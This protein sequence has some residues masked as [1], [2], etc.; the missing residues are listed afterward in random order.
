MM[1]A[2]DAPSRLPVITAVSQRPIATWRSFTGMRSPIT[3][4]PTGKMPPLA[5]PAIMRA[6]SSTV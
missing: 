2:S 1:P 6:A 4:M 5:M 3:A